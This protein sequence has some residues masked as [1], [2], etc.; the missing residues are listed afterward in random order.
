[1]LAYANCIYFQYSVVVC[2]SLTKSR[3][4][5]LLNYFRC[6]QMLVMKSKKTP[7][8]Q[9]SP[10]NPALNGSEQQHKQLVKSSKP[11]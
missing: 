4:K 3:K 8:N 1:M 5:L 2:L 6:K 10:V 7:N 9:P 11:L